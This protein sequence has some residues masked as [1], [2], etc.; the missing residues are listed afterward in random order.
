VWGDSLDGGDTRVKLIKV[1]LMTKKGRQFLRR[2]INRG[3]T[4]EMAEG[5][6]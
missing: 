3:D 6:D 4:A 5:D 2:K 1:T